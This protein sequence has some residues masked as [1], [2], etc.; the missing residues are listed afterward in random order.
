M[1]SGVGQGVFLDHNDSGRF[2]CRFVTVK[3]QASPSV[4]LRGMEDTVFGVWSAHG[5]GRYTISLK[6][7]IVK[8]CVSGMLLLSGL[9]V[10][11]GVKHCMFGP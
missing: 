2:E 9:L 4:M 10:T 5:E 6:D 8:Q 1:D 3:V 11:S 7:C